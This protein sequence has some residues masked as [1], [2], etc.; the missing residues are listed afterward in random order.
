MKRFHLQ[1]PTRFVETRLYLGTEDS[2][3]IE[4]MLHLL[5]VWSSAATFT[6]DKASSNTDCASTNCSCKKRAPSNSQE[7]FEWMICKLANDFQ[8]TI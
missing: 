7:C 6:A 5:S 8:T 4:D 3:Q 1:L 2:D